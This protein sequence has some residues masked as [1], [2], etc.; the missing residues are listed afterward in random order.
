MLPDIAH[1]WNADLIAGP[2]G[3]LA[4]RT[5]ATMVQQRI[6]R[7]L[8]TNAGDYIWNPDYGAGLSG[9]VGQIADSDRIAAIVGAQ[10]VKEPAVAKFPPPSI[11]AEM[12]G[13][14]GVVVNIKYQDAATEASA[15]LALT[16]PR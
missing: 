12:S 10:I 11:E 14:R 13:D 15:T 2:S 6:V 4:L 7:R 16:I 1:E 9:F 8:L 5:G 3:D